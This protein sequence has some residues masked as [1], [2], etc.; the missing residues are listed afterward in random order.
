MLSSTSQRLSQCILTTGFIFAVIIIIFLTLYNLRDVKGA[1]IGSVVQ[2]VSDA[3]DTAGTAIHE[4]I[5][6]TPL[7]LYTSGSDQE[8]IKIGAENTSLFAITMSSAVIV[9]I[10]SI[11]ATPN[12]SRRAFITFLEVDAGKN[13]GDE[14]QGTN[15]DNEGIYFVGA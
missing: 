11:A 5:K 10:S 6:C 14:A 4:V 2:F 12:E 3:R 8:K 7:W 15:P 13:H 9:V 1:S